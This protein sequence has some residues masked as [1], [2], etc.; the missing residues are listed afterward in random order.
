MTKD[1]IER[2]IAY[3]KTQKDIPN[4]DYRVYMINIYNYISDKCKENNNNWCY[5]IECKE[6][7]IKKIITLGTHNSD[8]SLTECRR[9]IKELH[10]L[11][12]IKKRFVEG[13]WREYKIKEIDF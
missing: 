2:K 1:A 10:E 11:G 12:Y 7:D 8:M 9:Y 6:W 13:T 3:L 4:A 5:C